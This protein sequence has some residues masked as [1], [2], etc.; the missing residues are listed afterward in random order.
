[1]DCKEIVKRRFD[2]QAQSIS[3]WSVTNN[4][5]YIQ[6]YFDFIGFEEEDE[7]LDVACGTGEFSVFCARRLK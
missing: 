5:E 3:N 6:E 2:L 7:L 4:E 1:M